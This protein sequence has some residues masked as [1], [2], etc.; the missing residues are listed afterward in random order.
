MREGSS[1]N[2]PSGR[3]RAGFLRLRRSNTRIRLKASLEASALAIGLH[4]VR[5]ATTHVGGEASLPVANL[6]KHEH[7]LVLTTQPLAKRVEPH[8][9]LA[10]FGTDR[11]HVVV[12]RHD[13]LIGSECELDNYTI[14]ASPGAVRHPRR[15]RRKSP[16]CRAPSMLSAQVSLGPHPTG[17]GFVP[18]APALLPGSRRDSDPA[19]EQVFEGGG[20]TH[21]ID[22]LLEVKSY[23]FL[24]LIQ[25]KFSNRSRGNPCAVDTW[26]AWT[27]GSTLM[28][29]AGRMI[30]GLPVSLNS[31][32]RR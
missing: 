5:R 12:F 2:P 32:P 15:S 10:Q 26:R 21:F 31:S 30:D 25:E 27:S 23:V 9:A 14:R 8:E 1:S 28:S 22:G 3:T 16:G 19:V 29:G 11:H 6:L 13:D 17:D 7:D 4:P 18:W 20:G 24:V